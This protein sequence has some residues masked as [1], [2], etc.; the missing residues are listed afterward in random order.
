MSR[1]DTDLRTRA[2]QLGYDRAVRPI[3]FRTAGGD[4]EAAHHRT[5][6]AVGAL[7]GRRWA[8]AAVGR[9]LGSP[10]EPV[11][12]LGLRFPNRVGLAAGMDKDGTAVGGWGALGFGHVELGTVTAQA[13]PGNERPRLFR[14]PASRAVLN[15]M[16]FNNAGVH[17][18]AERLRDARAQGRVGIPVGVSIGKT[19][20]TPLAEAVPDYLTSVTAL[21]GLADYLAVNVSSPN[22]PGL[23]GLQDAEP[24]AELLGAVVD[25]THAL[26]GAAAP[27]PVLVKLA[28]DLD[29]RALAEALEVAT[30]AGVAGFIATNT[31]TGRGGVHPSEQALADRESGGLSGAPLTARSR[32]V[33]TRIRSLTDLPLIGVGGVLSGGDGAALLEA[34]AD[35]V[36]VYSGLVYAGPALVREVA[37]AGAAHPSR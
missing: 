31:T 8:T 11:D 5:V 37:A 22:T 3:L 28:P 14:L 10:G 18:L 19:K 4:A 34:G 36:Q 15:R 29:D 17:A 20:V 35:L 7:G 26:A 33:V 16:G 23:R 30:G 24:L 27:T 12:L 25:R 13:Q 6:S 9:A 32:E 2:L 21:H 1:T